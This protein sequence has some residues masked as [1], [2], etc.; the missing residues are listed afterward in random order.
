M[1]FR[2]VIGDISSKVQRRRAKSAVRNAGQLV[3][4]HMHRNLYGVYESK[5]EKAKKRDVAR[6]LRTYLVAANRPV[7][8]EDIER[9]GS[10]KQEGFLKDA[11]EFVE[12]KLKGEERVKYEQA[13]LRRA[14]RLKNRLKQIYDKRP[15]ASGNYSVP[16]RRTRYSD[17]ALYEESPASTLIHGINRIDKL[18]GKLR[19]REEG[20]AAKATAIIS[21]IGLIGAIF[22]LSTNITGNAIANVTNST[23]NI[24]G[25]C[26][27]V[28][29]LVCSFFWLRR[30]KL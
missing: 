4:F 9:G 8:V 15:E 14:E 29:G 22:F 20:L 16:L 26:L 27:L 28:V 21:I 2:S 25:A 30:R 18:I 24:V 11:F 6:Q 17:P 13:I 19:G 12:E 1:G 7:N 3:P 10:T 5:Y 23:S